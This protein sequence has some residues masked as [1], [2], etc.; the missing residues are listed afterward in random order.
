MPPARP[1]PAPVNVRTG[2]LLGVTSALTFSTLGVWGKLAGQVGL[3][4]FNALA[5]RFG[6]VALLLLPLT[7]RGLSGADRRRMLGVGVLYA[8]ATICYFGALGRI[9]AGATGLLLYLAPAFVILLA[10]LSGRAPR[11]TQLGAV[12]LASAG[13]ALVVG[14][15]GP[16][17]RDPAGLLLGAGAGVLYATYLLASERLLTGVPALASTAH[18]ALV[19]ALVFTGLA[20]GGGA[21]GVPDTAAQWG[22]IAA[23]AL[24]PT[25]IAVP[26]LYGAVRHLGAARTSLLGTLEPLFTLILAGALLA[27]WPARP[28]PAGER[29]A[30]SG[31]R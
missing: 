14:L 7:S 4:S 6:L 13:L 3:D 20:A 31:R 5:W 22:V 25:L 19:A 27:Q 17:D 30:V 28:V 15:P 24:L 26:A 16:A 9:T 8:A 11:R 12:T 10:W 18:M 29:R 23:M 2:L 1:A 21:L